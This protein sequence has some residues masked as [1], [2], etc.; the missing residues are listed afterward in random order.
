M[1]RQLLLRYIGEDGAKG[2]LKHD[3]IYSAAIYSSNSYFW[4]RWSED[5]WFPY[6][7]LDALLK[8]WRELG[9]EDSGKCG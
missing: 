3:Q 5:R 2:G 6:T 1:K 9:K 4:V 8:D 7:S